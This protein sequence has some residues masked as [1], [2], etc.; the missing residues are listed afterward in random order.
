MIVREK[1]VET[2]GPDYVIQEP[3]ILDSYAKDLSFVSSIRP[4]FLVKLRNTDD[5]I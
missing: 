4:E 5:A 2:F 1:L 3:A